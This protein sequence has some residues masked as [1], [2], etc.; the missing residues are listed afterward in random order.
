VFVIEELDGLTRAVDLERHS[1]TLIHVPLKHTSEGVILLGQKAINA[2][3]ML[4][5]TVVARSDSG[6]ASRVA[7][8]PGEQT[9]DT[10]RPDAALRVDVH[11]DAVAEADAATAW[12]RDEAGDDIASRFVGDIAAALRV[13]ADAPLRSPPGAD[14][15]RARRLDAFPYLVVY[16]C[17]SDRVRVLALAHTSRPPDY[18]SSR[19]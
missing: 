1:A 17:L 3:V 19:R 4:P 9:I 7:E 16:E 14:G 5:H 12:Y 15:T 8:A 6:G 18:W 2:M 10:T 13:I 11:D